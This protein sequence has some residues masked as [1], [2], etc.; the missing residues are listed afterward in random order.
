[1]ASSQPGPALSGLLVLVGCVSEV[2]CALTTLKQLMGVVE[3]LA[4]AMA[5]VEA[6]R[7]VSPPVSADAPLYASRDG[8][9]VETAWTETDH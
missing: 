2:R 9:P 6:T 7:A 5:P 1:M 8:A 4:V 3:E